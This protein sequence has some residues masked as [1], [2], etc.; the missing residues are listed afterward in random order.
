MIKNPI[1]NKENNYTT[2]LWDSTKK[3]FNNY[4]LNLALTLELLNNFI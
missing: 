3:T 1:T 4:M 2:P